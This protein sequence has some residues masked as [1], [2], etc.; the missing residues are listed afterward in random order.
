MTE[1]EM[2]LVSIITPSLNQGKYLKC[3]LESVMNQNYPNIE[4]IIIDG[5]STDRTIQI[6][7]EHQD[8]YNVH[9]ISEPDKGQ[10]DAINKGLKLAKGDII[11]WINSDDAY[12]SKHSLSKVVEYFKNHT[13]A[14]ILSGDCAII[15]NKNWVRSIKF[16][17]PVI[18]TCVLSR[19]NIILQPSVFFRK[20]I[21][22]IYQADINLNYTMDY[23]LWLRIS[24]EYKIYHF[25]EI[26]SC[27][28]IHNDSKTVSSA[29]MMRSEYLDV[30]H[31]HQPN[32]KD[33]SLFGICDIIEIMLF[34]VRFLPVN[35]LNIYRLKSRHDFAFNIKIPNRKN[36][37][38]SNFIPGRLIKLFEDYRTF[39]K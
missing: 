4:H 10:S 26:L 11:G 27:F 8:L 1:K 33:A 34:V 18:C 37:I 28:R 36:L 30:I 16:C 25:N 17:L 19:R 38:K 39:T 23:D 5:G 12:L 20:N 35:M 14:N 29:E 13:D 15:D 9:W 3:N 24:S 32:L 2:P 7:T 21:A 6:L 31:K 22:D